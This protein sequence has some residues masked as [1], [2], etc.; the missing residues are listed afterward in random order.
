[1]ATKTERMKKRARYAA[2]IAMA[3]MLAVPGSPSRAADPVLDAASD[4]IKQNRHAAAVKAL[5]KALGAGKLSTSDMS[6]A[7]YYRGIAYRAL[8]KPAQSIADLTN[9]IWLGGLSPAERA[10]ALKHRSQAYDSGGESGRAKSDMAEANRLA[11]KLPAK[12]ATSATPA[13][14]AKPATNAQDS[15]KSSTWVTT[16]ATQPGAATNKPAG[17]GLTSGITGFFGNIFGGSSGS[18]S[19][20]TVVATAPAVNSVTQAP[21]K[22]VKPSVK[23]PAKPQVK[24]AVIARAKPKAPVK[25]VTTGWAA[26]IDQ[27]APQGSIGQSSP[28]A[29]GSGGISS[30]FG[31]WFGGSSKPAQSAAKPAQTAAVD[32]KKPT[33]E[34]AA[35]QTPA[36]K[37]Q[38]PKGRVKLQIATVR[39]K[40]EAST[41]V[42][43][44][45][46]NHSTVVARHPA[47]IDEAVMGNMGTFYRVRLEAFESE[48]TALRTC[49]KLRA[50]GLDC[51]P[52]AR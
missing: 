19:S 41:I 42:S 26:N 47:R 7:L 48:K 40:D 11:S 20:G 31:N 1:M 10:D 32:V 4:A 24:P 17:G 44:L 8:K 36:K 35:P 21:K 22:A 12:S 5:D 51:F 49:N 14:R 3:L 43:N 50:T 23:K 25:Q 2:A 30:Y 52:V 45:N 39:S 38:R 46:A 37:A 27:G 33:P 28:G 34:K 13:K 16:S 6:K 29:S 9:A 15:S 18:G